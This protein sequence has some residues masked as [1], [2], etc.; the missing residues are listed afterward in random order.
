MESGYFGVYLWSQAVAKAQSTK[1]DL[2]RKALK[3]Q[4]FNAPEGMI[5]LNEDSQHTC[6]FVRIGKIRSDKQFNI[7]WSSQKAVRP[8]SYPPFR[9]IAEWNN[10][11]VEM[12]K[13]EGEQ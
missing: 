10:L 11:L 6:L 3:N 2:V 12:K 5:Y 9:S 8:L 1:T 4:Y 13:K 7:L